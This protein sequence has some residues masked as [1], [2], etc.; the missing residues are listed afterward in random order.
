[1]NI[2]VLVSGG[3]TNLQNLIDRIK[4]GTLSGVRICHVIASK[5]GTY[6]Q[7]RAEKAGLPFSVVRRKDYPDLDSYD[8]TLLRL[9]EQNG[10]ELVVLGGFLSLLGPRVVDRYRNRILNI[11]PALLPAFGGKGM[12]GLHVHEAVLDSGVKWTGATV[13]FINE[14]YDEG[15]ILLQL[16]VP[17]KQDDTPESLQRG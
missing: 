5:E 6:A 15:P 17:V 7:P 1:M 3:G 16:P 8:E 12:Y 10:T 11:H 14:N 9:L 13:H 4:D 2:A